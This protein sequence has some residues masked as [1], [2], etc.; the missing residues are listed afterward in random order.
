MVPSKA[1]PVAASPAEP[2][3]R[4]STLEWRELATGIAALTLLAIIASAILVFGRPGALHGRT[5]P[6]HV[7]FAEA[8]GVSEGTAVWLAGQEI[9]RV[10][11]VAFRPPSAGGAE[12]L[13][14]ELAIL[15][16]FR[17]Q[18]RE[19]ARVAI[20]PGGSLFGAPVVYLS[21]GNPTARVV[22]AG[23]TLR[24]V[25]PRDR[26]AVVGDIRTLGVQLPQLVGN[27]RVVAAQIRN[28]AGS[29]GA[30]LDTAS[31]IELATTRQELARL[32]RAVDRLADAEGELGSLQ[33]RAIV[34]ASRADSIRL[35]LDTPVGA[36]GRFRRDSTLVRRISEVSTEVAALQ[37]IAGS[38]E[39]TIGQLGSGG[40]LTVRLAAVRSALDR[41]L[42]D[43]RAN[44]LRYINF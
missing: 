26:D 43:V 12:R 33:R 28:G 40:A 27:V 23:D 22:H 29:V 8:P 44:P 21:F 13:V 6:L 36:I 11:G 31:D 1:T 34:A 39:G 2:P 30:L 41:L 10:R 5:F 35:L 3:R 25:D 4:R 24:G 9:G 37:A 18:I 19:D 15:S 32:G 14:V 38:R 7:V 16:R 17:R 20:Q 42:A